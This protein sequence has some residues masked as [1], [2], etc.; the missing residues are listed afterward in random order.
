MARKPLPKEYM[1]P[2]ELAGLM[3][4]RLEFMCD[5]LR[6]DATREHKQYPFATAICNSE[7]GTWSYRIHRKRF[8]QWNKGAD[9]PFSID[10][11]AEMVADKIL[12]R[13]SEGQELPHQTK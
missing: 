13:L 1:L 6:R 5:E 3:G 9:M 2:A 4:R 8:E 7:T 11:L 10:Q 12:K